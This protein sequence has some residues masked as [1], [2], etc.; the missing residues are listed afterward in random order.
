MGSRISALYYIVKSAIQDYIAL[1]DRISSSPGIPVQNSSVPF[2]TVPNSPIAQHGADKELPEDADVVIIGS[3]ITGASI[4]KTILENSESPIRVV[5][6]EARDACSGAS[7]RC[8][9]QLQLDLSF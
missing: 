3:G 5:M 6:L 8:V 4:A 7:G 1:S 2:W 9:L